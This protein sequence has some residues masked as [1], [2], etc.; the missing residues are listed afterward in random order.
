MS[1][2]PEMLDDAVALLDERVDRAA[3]PVSRCGAGAAVGVA[4][5]PYLTTAEAARYMRKSV[6]WLLRRADLPFLKGTPNLY[7]RR[8]LDDWFDRNKWKPKV[9]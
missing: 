9:R 6:S 4:G 8:D 1:S 2:T 7:S 5:S 3:A